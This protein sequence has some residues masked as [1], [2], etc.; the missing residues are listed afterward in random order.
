MLTFAEQFGSFAVGYLIYI[1]KLPILNQLFVVASTS[2]P[3]VSYDYTLIQLY[4]P[5]A[6]FLLFFTLRRGI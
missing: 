1:R 5:W 6:A 4:I 3:F 2:F